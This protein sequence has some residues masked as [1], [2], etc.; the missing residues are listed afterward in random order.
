MATGTLAALNAVTPWLKPIDNRI[1]FMTKSS[2]F[3]GTINIEISP[4]GGS[5]V[6]TMSKDV[7]GNAASY[8]NTE[9]TL[10]ATNLVPGVSCRMKVSAYTSGSM[11]YTIL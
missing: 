11:G 6:Y 8:I 3:V 2:S 4:D 1:T 9:F 7:N 10:V 5:T